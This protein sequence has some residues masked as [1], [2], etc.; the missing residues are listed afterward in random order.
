[1]KGDLGSLIWIVIVVL[2]IVG[3]LLE[4]KGPRQPPVARQGRG[5]MPTMRPPVQPTPPAPNRSGQ[6]K[7]PKPTRSGQTSTVQTGRLVNQADEDEGISLEDVK[8]T[9]HVWHEATLQ[10]E[11]APQ[12][13]V[14][15]I[16]VQQAVVWAEILGKPVALR[17]R[18]K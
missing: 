18:R 1:M 3:K 15:Q 8:P 14:Q 11:A 6:P 7:P 16:P 4:K 17:G 12:P 5:G 2:G 9:V 10:P 13:I